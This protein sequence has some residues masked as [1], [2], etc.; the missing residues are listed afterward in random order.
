MTSTSNTSAA[1]CTLNEIVCPL[2]S[3]RFTITPFDLEHAGEYGSTQATVKV[4][5]YWGSS[6]ATVYLNRK[7]EWRNDGEVDIRTHE[8]KC[9]L[10]HSSG[11][12][13]TKELTSDLEAARN[14]ASAVDALALYAEDVIEETTIIDELERRYTA[15]LEAQRAVWAAEKAAAAAALEADKAMGVDSATSLLALAVATSKHERR[16]VQL[17]LYARGAKVGT[18]LTVTTSVSGAAMIR[19]MN[20]RLISRAVAVGL[21][22]QGSA[23]SLMLPKPDMSNVQ[24]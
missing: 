18:M 2:R 6:M 14:F 19:D 9:E 22:A 13:D 1:V 8:W 23:R 16:Y 7:S 3:A 24:I 17:C 4:V 5:G 10:S 20:S 12:R 15:K 11:G 21:L